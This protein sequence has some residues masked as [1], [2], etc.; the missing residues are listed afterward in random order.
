MYVLIGLAA[1]VAGIVITSTVIIAAFRTNNA[2]RHKRKVRTEKEKIKRRPEFSKIVLALVLSTY[3][4][5]VGVGVWVIALDYSQLS[6]VLAFI[7]TPTA[8]ALG[9][10]T[11]KARAENTIKLKKDNPGETESISVDF[12]RY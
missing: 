4:V 1:F 8:A 9:F 6:V 12:E 10:Y 11:W 3:F 5:G 7:G 2:Q